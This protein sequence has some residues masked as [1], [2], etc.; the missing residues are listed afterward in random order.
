M[1]RSFLKIVAKVTTKTKFIGSKWESR[2]CRNTL[3]RNEFILPSMTCFCCWHI[4]ND[5]AI[6]R[7]VIWLSGYIT[8]ELPKSIEWPI[9]D[10][11]RIRMIPAVWFVLF[12]SDFQWFSSLSNVCKI[13]VFAWKFVYTYGCVIEMILYF[14]WKIWK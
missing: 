10:S 2:Y 11:A 6:F 13:T 12:H 7:F 8:Q 3:R 1:K 14:G 4:N 9:N 5:S